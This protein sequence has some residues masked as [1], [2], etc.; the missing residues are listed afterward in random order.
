MTITRLRQIDTA[1]WERQ[2]TVEPLAFRPSLTGNNLA[3]YLAVVPDI[4]ATEPVT[5]WSPYTHV[6]TA[7]HPEHPDGAVYCLVVQADI[8]NT[9]DDTP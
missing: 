3:D 7:T 8:H 9:R 6:A 1:K 4:V 5:G 2:G